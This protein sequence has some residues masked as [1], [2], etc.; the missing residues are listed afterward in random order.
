M[1][2]LF[3]NSRREFILWIFLLLFI[4]ILHGSALHGN[5][6]WDDTRHLSR[7]IEYSPWQYF[8]IPRITAAVSGYQLTP[9][10]VFV[11]DINL[12]LFGL[13]PFWFYL[14]HLLSLWLVAIF[15]YIL[16]RNWQGP[17]QSFYG[18]F[19][20]LIGPPF[21]TVSQQ[22]MTG[23]YI[24][25]LVF[26]SVMLHLYILSL[27][28][29]SLMLSFLSSIFYL[30]S[31]SCKEV[32]VPFV[33]LLPFISE[34]LSLPQRARYF[35]FHIVMVVGYI[36]WRYV[37]LGSATGPLFRTSGYRL[38]EI[39]SSLVS[40]FYT[41]FGSSIFSWFV[42]GCMLIL[43]V[44]SIFT[45][46][47]KIS[48]LLISFFVMFFPLYRLIENG[49]KW[50]GSTRYLFAF[51]WLLCILIINTMF[52]LKNKKILYFVISILTIAVVLQSVKQVQHDRK[53]NLMFDA[54]YDAVFKTRPPVLIY[55]ELAFP[56]P[57]YLMM[58][59]WDFRSIL[60]KLGKVKHND[61]WPFLSWTPSDNEIDKIILWNDEC[62]CMK[63][64]VEFP[65]TEKKKVIDQIKLIGNPRL[66]VFYNIPPLPL[67]DKKGG[68]VDSVKQISNKVEIKGRLNLADN[69]KKVLFLTLDVH[70]RS[71]SITRQSGL[72]RVDNFSDNINSVFLISLEFKNEEDA[73]RATTNFCILAMGFEPERYILSLLDNLPSH[74]DG[75][76]K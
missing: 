66:A 35:L 23:H 13:R 48:I 8:F 67:V 53:V 57:N 61:Y 25:G 9:W 44:W 28:N 31:V 17:I 15:T 14:H 37:T 52:A 34:R 58:G 38:N 51:W 6:R 2:E 76:L 18:A 55:T 70:P 36:F 4:F 33:L 68:A 1:L 11:Y 16:I 22:L 47:M 43:L 59:L 60:K 46:K 32:Y 40:I 73:K 45:R 62:L 63:K 29:Q 49:E 75:F 72:D 69:S 64:V 74:C 39:L 3:L 71:Y 10:N 21:F 41:L 20:F 42:V 56:E 24:Y 26:A 30:L 19:L 65:E 7:A 54:H 5:W 12:K 27:K 50:I